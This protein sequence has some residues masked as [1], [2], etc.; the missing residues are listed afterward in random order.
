LMALQC[1]DAMGAGRVIVIGRGERLKKAA[2]FGAETVDFE[3]VDVVK[4]VREMT[5][6]IGVDAVIETAG[7][8]KSCKEAIEII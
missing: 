2:D 1:A 8:P 3:A 4:T 7:Q 5:N 6:D